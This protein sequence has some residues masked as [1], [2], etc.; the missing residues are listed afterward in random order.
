MYNLKFE[1]VQNRLQH[2]IERSTE[3]ILSRV[4]DELMRLYSIY[5][6]V[7]SLS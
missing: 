2:A 4:R 7:S 3:T 1:A 5:I 6:Y